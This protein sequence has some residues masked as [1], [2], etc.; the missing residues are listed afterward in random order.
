MCFAK[1]NKNDTYAPV[2]ITAEYSPNNICWAGSQES[3]KF[4]ARILS[5]I[6]K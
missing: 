2:S 6:L 5:K 4:M 3:F 1:H